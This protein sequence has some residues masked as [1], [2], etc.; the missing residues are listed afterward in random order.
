M[1]ENVR[2]IGGIG[3]VKK[4]SELDKLDTVKACG[5]GKSWFLATAVFLT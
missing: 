3:V 2:R 1:L 5:D 4:G